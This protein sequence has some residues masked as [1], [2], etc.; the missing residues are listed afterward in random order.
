[1]AVTDADFAALVGRV[2]RLE[3]G[4]TTL[5]TSFTQAVQRLTGV[6]QLA[7]TGGSRLAA[8]EAAAQGFATRVD[9]VEAALRAGQENI[10]GVRQRL[11]ELETLVAQLQ[12]TVGTLGVVAR[13]GRTVMR[14]RVD[15][16]QATLVTILERLPPTGGT[17]P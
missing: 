8:L 14:Q 15:D 16:I 12:T 6:E 7:T 13:P 4:V 9:A 5:Q 2:Q 11:T 10:Q 17:T 1:M 3:T